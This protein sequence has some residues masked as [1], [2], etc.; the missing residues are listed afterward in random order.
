MSERALQIISEVPMP[1]SVYYYLSNVTKQKIDVKI[2]DRG[3]SDNGS[4][5]TDIMEDDDG[6][7]SL[8]EQF[9]SDNRFDADEM[10]PVHKEPHHKEPE[11]EDSV[12][13]LHWI[14]FRYGHDLL[15][16]PSIHSVITPEVPYELP[17]YFS[18]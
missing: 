2:D 12:E 7:G 1:Q 14:E 6:F 10:E 4:F 18:P 9:S 5:N 11:E 15:D 8:N 17:I 13:H 3:E 16:N